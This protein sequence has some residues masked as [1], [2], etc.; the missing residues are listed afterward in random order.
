[1]PDSVYFFNVLAGEFYSRHWRQR[2]YLDWC[3]C[4][5]D[6]GNSGIAVHYNSSR[7][8]DL[9]SSKQQDP[10]FQVNREIFQPRAVF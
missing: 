4:S 9:H 6:R 10:G 1:M 8:Q 5:D 2:G 7:D 3:F